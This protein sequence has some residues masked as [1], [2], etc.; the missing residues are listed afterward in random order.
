MGRH[1]KELEQP[2]VEPEIGFE[3]LSGQSIRPEFITKHWDNVR[4]S[5]ERKKAELIKN[6]TPAS[7]VNQ[8]LSYTARA[9]EEYIR[10]VFLP[11]IISPTTGRWFDIP[12][13][14]AASKIVPDAKFTFPTHPALRVTHMIRYV[15]AEHEDYLVRNMTLYGFDM[16]G[17]EVWKSIES[18]DYYEEPIFRIEKVPSSTDTYSRPVAIAKVDGTRWKF[19]NKFS[20]EKVLYALNN[21][22]TPADRDRIGLSI[23]YEKSPYWYGGSMGAVSVNL[24]QFIEPDFTKL[25]SEINP[26]REKK[27]DNIVSLNKDDYQ[28]FLDFQEYK[29]RL[30]EN[31]S[32]IQ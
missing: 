8:N 16:E 30:Q 27:S 20:K 23:R 17:N 19:L 14:K 7:M 6:G 21:G 11:K 18:P 1:K 4:N 2:T 10:N 13:L 5:I 28:A 31:D 3:P 29:K 25:W 22:V 9:H 32:H 26:Y 24:K 15:T 12:T